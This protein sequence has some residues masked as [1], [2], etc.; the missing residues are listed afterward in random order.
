M[1]RSFVSVS[2]SRARFHTIVRNSTWT[3]SPISQCRP[4]GTTPSFKSQPN[5]TASQAVDKLLS[6]FTN[7]ST[8]RRQ[9]LD[10]NQLQKLSLTLGRRELDGVDVSENP[11]P[12]GTPVPP[13]WHLVYFTPNG[14]ESQL[15]ADGTDR[16]FNAPAPFTRRMWA[17]GRMKWLGNSN[18]SNSPL[19][20]VGDEVEERTKFVSATAKKNKAGRE[21]VLV[22]IEKEFW[23]PRGLSL[24]DQRS[25]SS[26]FDMSL[27]TS[28]LT[29]LAALGHGSSR[30]KSVLV[31]P[32]LEKLST[33]ML[34][35]LQGL[36]TSRRTT[37]VSRSDALKTEPRRADWLDWQL[38]PDAACSG[39]PSDYSASPH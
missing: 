33:M 16:S 19:L 26:S 7:A 21:M 14:L 20:R 39:L 30:L 9:I 17:G 37:K 38:S 36:R 5:L 6:S 22:E 13:G 35:V 31:I 18:D 4:F 11:P 8:V 25:V 24:V 12:T 10:A 15:G 23:G 29:Q 2:A 34:K 27:A 3:A 1:A 28:I 32:K